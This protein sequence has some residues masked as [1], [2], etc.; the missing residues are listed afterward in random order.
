MSSAEPP[1]CGL[2]F[3]RLHQCLHAHACFIEEADGVAVAVADQRDEQMLG[4]HIA[5]A[6]TRRDRHCRTQHTL[7]ARCECIG[8]QMRRCAAD[9]VRLDPLGNTVGRDAAACQRCI[10]HAAALLQESEQHMLG[11]HIAVAE[12]LRRLH[13]EVECLIGFF[14]ESLELEHTNPSL[15]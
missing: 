11:A 15:V 4:T 5:A 3:G 2:P 9:L 1:S 13:G 14:G 8:G 12:L 7:G 10:C 6:D